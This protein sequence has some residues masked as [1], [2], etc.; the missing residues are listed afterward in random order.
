MQGTKLYIGN[1]SSSISVE[2][3]EELFSDYG[4]VKKIKIYSDRNSAMVEMFNK[5]DAVLA[6]QE[7][8]GLNFAGNS[9]IISSKKLNKT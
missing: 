2:L 3:L 4:S 7:L 6:K 8:N 5:C 1:L 9:L